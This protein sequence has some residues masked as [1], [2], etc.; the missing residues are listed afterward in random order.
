MLTTLCSARETAAKGTERFASRVSLVGRDTLSR[1]VSMTLEG[2]KSVSEHVTKK[3]TK[4]VD[5]AVVQ[6]LSPQGLER[7]YII[8]ITSSYCST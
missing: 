7:S 5:F 6:P 4:T 8:E 1:T 3:V 2:V